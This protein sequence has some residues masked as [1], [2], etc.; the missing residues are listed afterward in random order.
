MIEISGLGEYFSPNKLVV[1]NSEGNNGEYNFLDRGGGGIA[2][3]NKD[4]NK[5]KIQGS[6]KIF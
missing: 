2:H 5:E 1:T 3:V 6:K 4:K